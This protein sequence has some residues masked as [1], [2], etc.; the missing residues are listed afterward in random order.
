MEQIS[1]G[2]PFTDAVTYYL[3]QP[4]GAP[5]YL[6]HIVLFRSGKII[7]PLKDYSE[8]MRLLT[9]APLGMDNECST[10]LFSLFETARKRLY[11]IEFDEFNLIY[12]EIIAGQP[13][14]EPGDITKK[15]VKQRTERARE[16]RKK[17]L[18][19]SE[20]APSPK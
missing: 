11:P 3:T 18:G 12:E 17:K 6:R 2:Y 15:L 8:M 10:K 1:T 5:K 4:G 7:N 19:N 16:L 14:Y 13:L 9:N 20:N